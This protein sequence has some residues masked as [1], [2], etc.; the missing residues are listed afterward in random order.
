MGEK[1]GL[2]SNDLTFVSNY[3]T[4]PKTRV[5]MGKN[6]ERSQLILYF[7]KISFEYI[8]NYAELFSSCLQVFI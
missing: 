8:V 6:Y 2:F 7:L 3:I 4:V 5:P 1:V